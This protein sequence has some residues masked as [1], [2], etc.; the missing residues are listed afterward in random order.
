MA[1]KDFKEYLITVQQQWL[2]LKADLADF[3]QAF[4]DGFITEDKLEEVK[5]EVAQAEI[6]YQRLIYVDYLLDLPSRRKKK[7]LQRQKN[8]ARLAALK[9]QKADKDSVIAENKEHTEKVH[10]LL[11]ELTKNEQE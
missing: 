7:Y 6:N 9:E 10:D 5:N 2:E 11:T 3:E 1:V 4:K 8:K